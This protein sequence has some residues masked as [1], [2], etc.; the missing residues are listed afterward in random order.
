MWATTHIREN[1]FAGI[2]TTSLCEVYYS[3]MGQF[4]HSKMN[5]T[6]F[7]KK[8]HRC[9]AYFFFREVKA[10]FQSQYGQAMLQTS[11]R[12]LERSASK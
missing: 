9:V 8:I 7:I 11:L 4:V 10:Y 3:H 12:V 5:M 1:F 6:Y 2:T